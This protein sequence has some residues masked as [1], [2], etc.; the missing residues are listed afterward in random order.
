M[1]VERDDEEILEDEILPSRGL[2]LT[3][4]FNIHS[5][6]FWAALGNGETETSVRLRKL[7]Y[8]L[9]SIPQDLR[10][11]GTASGHLATIRANLHVTHLWLQSILFDQLEQVEWAERE[12]ISRQLLHVLHS[13]PHQNLEPNGLHL[14]SLSSSLSITDMADLQGARCRCCA[15][16]LST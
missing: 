3:T 4:G 16:C 13:I 11:W 6:V 15:S 2:S 5:R 7:K 9:D 14:V 8:M 10:Q 1:P 12:D